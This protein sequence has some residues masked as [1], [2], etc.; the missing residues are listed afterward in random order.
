M[1]AKRS[2]RIEQLYH[3]AREYDPGQRATFLG[4]ACAGDDA[5][6]QEVESLLAEDGG[7]ESFLET[8][9]LEL[10]KKISGEDPSQ[11]IIGRQLGP[12]CVVSLLAE[13][14]MGVVFRAHDTKLK[15]D[16]ALKLL[17]EHLA[18]DADRLARFRREAQVLAALNHLNI[19][20]IY[21][22]EESNNTRC[23]V[24]ELAEGETLAERI[25]RGPIPVGEA[26]KIAYQIADALEA[27]HEKGIVHRDLK[28]ANVKITPEGKVKVLD[29]GL[30]KALAVA[31]DPSD[32]MTSPKPSMPATT[33]GLILGT[34][35][36]MS[37]EQAK[38]AN[39]DQR[40]DI[41]S[42]GCLLFEMLT[43]R[44]AFVGYTVSEVI[45][46]VLAC[47]PDLS[48]LPTNLHPK[49]TELIRRCLDKDPKRR[50]QAIGD[51]RV[52]IDAIG[53]D[54]HGL[55]FKAGLAVQKPFWRRAIPVTAATLLAA[56]VTASVTWVMWVTR[57]VPSAPVARFT[58]VLPKGQNF[59]RTGRH[60]FALS[61]DG[62]SMVY[63]ANRQLYLKLLS[64]AEARPIP[65]TAQDIDEPF[66][67]PDGK[68]IGFYSYPEGKL[69]K[70]AITGGASVTLASV[71]NPWGATWYA[72][73]QIMIGQGTR[74]IFR[75]SANGGKP[76]TVIAA[77]QGETLHGPEVL[78]GG[79]A[80]LFTVATTGDDDSWDKAQIVVQSMKT[81]ARK[82]LISGGSD[83]RYVPTGHIV[84][85]L[86]GNLYAVG[87]DVKKRQVIGGPIPV[88]EG[89]MRSDALAFTGGAFFSTSNSGSLAVVPGTSSLVRNLRVPTLVDKNGSKKPLSVSAANFAGP[90]ISPD[91][92][93]VA[94]TIND[95]REIYISLYDISG[96][97]AMRRLT[98]GG[99]NAFP[100]WSRDGQRI[101]FQSDRE[102]DPALFWQ[103]ADGSGSAERLSKAETGAG[104]A[105]NQG[106]GRPFAGIIVPESVS[107][108]GKLITLEAG[109]G[110]SMVRLDGDR[111]L[112]PLIQSPPR[113]ASGSVFSPDGHWL[114]YSE[115]GPEQI[116]VQ[117]FP[118]TG[119][120]Y[121]ITN[122]GGCCPL[123]SPDGKQIFYLDDFSPSRLIA[124]DIQTRPAFVIG[125][126]TPL[127]IEG[128]FQGNGPRDYDITPDGKQ[129][130]VAFRPEEAQA[131]DRPIQ[132]INVVLNW[133]E[134]LK[135]RVPL[136]AK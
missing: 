13:G 83:A 107:P 22:V 119:T 67:S 60:V 124:V 102:G 9:A 30:A 133:F 106:P 53:D 77:K 98:F 2:E 14:G 20:Q 122:E 64:E 55:K 10:A 84:Y 43:G 18:D 92:K 90:R 73:D 104:H 105:L 38:G 72:E 94:V 115:T 35:E 130:I 135:H 108:D 62:S 121:Q 46:S 19:A 78:P 27:A 129:F 28:P 112:K 96:A 95:G 99:S 51:V 1:P 23:I 82:V 80:I 7:V 65:G 103:R 37:P 56:A 93:Q 116:Y 12:Y 4:H 120:T 17:P 63:V 85:A 86:G 36:Y 52:E 68:W 132:Q 125:Q 89:V 87:F 70:I 123:W 39:T 61:P 97:A 110:I 41:F 54:P 47:E 136:P 26:L 75:I 118:P 8:P 127:H 11:S 66:F 3:A 58:Y 40:S 128:F 111:K 79:D 33:A 50:W 6:R 48:A 71:L 91:G 59:T 45:A 117:P 76:E 100:L 44:R 69:K 32:L 21:G 5:L 29:F 57:P 42:F 113:A 49:I 16:V 101:I 25:R 109:N 74:G 126:S 15:R 24:M 34:P 131:A 81:G 114:A 134:E 88:V 31:P